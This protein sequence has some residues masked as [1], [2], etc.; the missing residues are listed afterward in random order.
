MNQSQPSTSFAR[1][2]NNVRIDISDISCL[3]PNLNLPFLIS[4]I[5][6]AFEK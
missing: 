1:G 6:K 2:K 5:F 4:N 3:F